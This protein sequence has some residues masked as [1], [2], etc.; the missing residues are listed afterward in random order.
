[1]LVPYFRMMYALSLMRGPNI[2]DWVNDQVLS[3]RETTTRAQ[4]PL[5]RNNPQIWNNFNTAFTNAYTDTA[6]KQ[7]LIRNLW[8]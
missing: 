6:K 4:N 5:D 7:P 1:M 8:H 3:I 2:D